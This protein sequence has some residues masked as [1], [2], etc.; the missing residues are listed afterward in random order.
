MFRCLHCTTDFPLDDAAFLMSDGR[1]GVCL[2]CF[3]RAT[4]GGTVRL[5]EQVRRDAAQAAGQ[6][7]V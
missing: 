3:E 7:E 4:V 1:R 5:P 2:P 6:G